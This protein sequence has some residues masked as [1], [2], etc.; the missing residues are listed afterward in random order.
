MTEPRFPEPAPD[1]AALAGQMEPAHRAVTPVER[2]RDEYRSFVALFRADSRFTGTVSD[3][4]VASPD[5]PV[6]VRRYLP[7]GHTHPGHVLVYIH[8]G[9]WV[10]GDLDTHDAFPREVAER[11]GIEVVS[12]DYR[13]APEHPF[14]AAFDD[15][16]AVVDHVAGT[17]RWIAV[18]G[19]S[20]GG[21][22]AAAISASRA[23]RAPVDAQVLI[24]PGLDVPTSSDRNLDGLGLDRDDIDYFWASYR[25]DAALSARLVPLLHPDPIP[26][27]PTLLTTAGSDPLRPDGIAYLRRL[28]DADV[29]ATYLPFPHLIHGW[30]ELA[31][32]VGSAGAARAVLI[33]AIGSLH[34]A[35]APRSEVTPT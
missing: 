4:L 7:R 5:G 3:E 1:L 22:L 18:C 15:C 26:A 16:V 33:D 6:P 14:P 35:T 31:D 19:D 24:Y 25:G 11:T 21:N 2:Q 30:L 20:A 28:L 23:D 29:P 27:P 10:L 17:A 8:G 34:Q 9:G 32:G 13:L 12:V